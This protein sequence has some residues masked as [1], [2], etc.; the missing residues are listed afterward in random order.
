MRRS[1]FVWIALAVVLPSVSNAASVYTQRPE[2]K[3]AI[4]LTTD[5]FDVH[6]DGVADDSE[7]LQHVIDRV[8]EMPRSGGQGILF[9]PEGRY[10]RTV[11]HDRVRYWHHDDEHGASPCSQP[12]G[13][14]GAAA[15]LA[16]RSAH[17]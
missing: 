15:S 17:S 10:R 16:A 12:V 3:A 6:G 13:Q 9:V 14:R 1:G 7:A 5:T 8:Q 11:G 4:Y 2:D